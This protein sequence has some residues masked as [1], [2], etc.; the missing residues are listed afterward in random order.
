MGILEA[1]STTLKLYSRLL[2]Y[3]LIEHNNNFFFNSEKIII[4]M[5]RFTLQ[6]VLPFEVILLFRT[7]QKSVDGQS[8]WEYWIYHVLQRQLTM[9]SINLF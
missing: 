7:A 9:Y 6:I 5:L 1:A 8:S 4:T 2:L 3:I